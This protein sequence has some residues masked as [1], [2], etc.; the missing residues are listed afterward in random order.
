[1]AID[2]Q[3]APLDSPETLTDWQ[4]LIDI[5]DT[6]A[7][8]FK[9]PWPVKNDN[10]IRGSCFYIG[11]A[12]YVAN[13]D[14]AISGTASDYIQMTVDTV[15]SLITPAYVSTLTDVTWNDQ[16][17]GW[18]DT[19]G[20]FY[21]FDENVAYGAGLI[22]FPR[23]VVYSR[24]KNAESAR[25]LST[26]MGENWSNCLASSVDTTSSDVITIGVPNTLYTAY[27][28]TITASRGQTLITTSNWINIFTITLDFGNLFASLG[29]FRVLWQNDDS[30]TDNYVRIMNGA[31]QIAYWNDGTQNNVAFNVTGLDIEASATLTVQYREDDPTSTR[32]PMTITIYSSCVDDTNKPNLLEYI[33]H[34]HGLGLNAAASV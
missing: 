29:A 19:T 17:N 26:A 2:K 4:R 31:T 16:W 21:V 12:W 22:D 34:S 25:A 27:N 10:I 30:D 7:L 14:V 15:N 6:L 32:G 8:S 20:H 3:T 11:G 1:M 33:F 28:K 23:T 5:T 9:N 13:V 18:Y 24:P